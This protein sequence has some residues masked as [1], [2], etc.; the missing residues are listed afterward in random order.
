MKAVRKEDIEDCI[1]A[2]TSFYHND[3]N[4]AQLRLHLDILASNFTRD[5]RA[6]ASVIDIKDY[7]MRMSLSERQLIGE[8]S[9]L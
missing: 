5:E 7:G 8:V 9:N 2:V 3:I 6:S 4:A 1:G